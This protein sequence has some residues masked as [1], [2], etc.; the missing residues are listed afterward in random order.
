MTV[1]DSRTG[2]SFEIA[3]YPGYRMMYGEVGLAW[4]V[5]A[6]K[7]AHIGMVLG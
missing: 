5:H 1:T 7:Q 2:V 3:I 4:G 6:S